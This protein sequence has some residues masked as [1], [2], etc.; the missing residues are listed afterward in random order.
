MARVPVLIMAA[1]P[2]TG[3]AVA[4]ATARVRHA[5]TGADLQ[6]YAARTGPA[7]AANPIVTDAFGR[8][9]AFVD[10]APL[11]I[12]YAG[13]GID[14]WTEYRD[15]APASDR[16]IDDLWL[17]AGTRPTLVEALPAAPEDGQEHYLLVD[18]AAA[19][20]GPYLWHVRRRN[21]NPDGTANASP[22]KWDVIH[23]ERGLALAQ[24]AANQAPA[25]GGTWQPFAT[26][27]VIPAPFAGDYEARIGSNIQTNGGN[28]ANM[29]VG[30]RVGAVNPAVN[31][32]LA[33]SNYSATA[34]NEHIQQEATR[35]VPLLGLAAGTT[36]ELRHYSTA[37]VGAFYASWLRLR[38]I[39]IA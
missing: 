2:A 35:D 10:R 36:I 32:P 22:Y 3:E 14:P 33:A 7:G 26:A 39:R 6:A 19:Y 18:K 21:T 25:G 8:G 20:G 11:R 17:P 4:G 27:L 13:G 34:A 37:A 31:A 28:A 23:A 15:V 9:L 29:A 12:D 24:V 38:P 16:G 5:E 1:D 30:V